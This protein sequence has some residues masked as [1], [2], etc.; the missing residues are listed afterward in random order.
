MFKNLTPE[1]EYRL[2]G[3]V[4]GENLEEL[5]DV[6]QD[7]RDMDGV[8]DKIEEAM[9]QFPAEDFL[10][11][12]ISELHEIAKRLRG[13]NKEDLLGVIESLDDIAQCTF[14]ASDYGRDELRKALNMIPV[15]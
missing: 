6:Y 12:A 7:N 8:D 3:Q 15:R 5:L 1:E 11:D 4:T 9:A 13:Q 2:T 10:S 14:N